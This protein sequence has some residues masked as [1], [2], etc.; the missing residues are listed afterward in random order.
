MGEVGPW[1]LLPSITA[2]NFLSVLGVLF[3]YPSP[4]VRGRDMDRRFGGRRV[5]LFKLETIEGTCRL[6]VNGIAEAYAFYV[7]QEFVLLGWV[8][9]IASFP[10]V[11]VV[12]TWPQTRSSPCQSV[13]LFGPSDVDGELVWSDSDPWSCVVRRI[14][15]FG[16]VL[17]SR[18]VLR[19][20]GIWYGSRRFGRCV[21]LG[22]ALFPAPT[23]SHGSG[24]NGVI[25]YVGYSKA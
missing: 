18:L 25:Q 9:R 6:K 4:V 19:G 10:Y 11:H 20:G 15:R 12:C 13:P 1:R 3:Q 8:A 16:L 5:C 23:Y 24:T 7:V 2:L 14:W 22:T 21:R 17:P